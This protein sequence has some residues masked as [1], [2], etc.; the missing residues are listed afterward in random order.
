MS[1]EPPPGGESETM[2]EGMHETPAMEGQEPA[3]PEPAASE[4]NAPGD[5]VTFFA[6]KE[7]T[8][9]KQFKAGDEIMFTVKDVDPDT[10]ELELEYAKDKGMDEGSVLDAMPEE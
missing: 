6:P 9:G 4:G 8:G 2:S 1:P 3:A 7:A 5:G 10:G